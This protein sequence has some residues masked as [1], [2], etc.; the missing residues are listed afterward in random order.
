MGSE[1]RKRVLGCA[2]GTFIEVCVQHQKLRWLGRNAVFH[3]QFRKG[4]KEITKSLGV[5]GATRLPGWGP[6]VTANRCQWRSCFPFLSRL[7]E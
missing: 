1:V 6:H 3:A 7:S 4:M 2:T 5:V